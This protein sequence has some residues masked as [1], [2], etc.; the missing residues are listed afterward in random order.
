MTELGTKLN[1]SNVRSCRNS[2]KSGDK[3]ED[4]G[5]DNDDDDVNRESNMPV[6]I[7]T[8]W[9]TLFQEQEIIFHYNVSGLAISFK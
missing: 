7:M 1:Q 9:P 5:C 2:S 3:D 8:H 4:D 6:I